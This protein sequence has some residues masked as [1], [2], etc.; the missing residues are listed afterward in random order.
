MSAGVP[1]VASNV[2]GIPEIVVDGETGLL[3]END[4]AQIAAAILRLK[5]DP[6]FGTRLAERARQIVME[7]FSIEAMIDGTLRAYARV[8]AC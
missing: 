4:A 8:L 2:G 1:V 6:A 3:V 5:Q 7:K